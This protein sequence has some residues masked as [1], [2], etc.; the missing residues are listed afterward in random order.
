MKFTETAISGVLLLVPEPA[1]DD[2]GF[3]ARTFDQ[4]EF[5]SRGLASVFVQRSIAFNAKA[6][7]IRGLHYQISPEEEEKIVRCTSGA[8]FDVAVDLRRD[9]PTFGSYS[10]VELTADNRRAFY[11]P[12]GVAHGYQTLSEA[13][14]VMYDISRPYTAEAA[15]GIAYDDPTLAI[16]WPVDVTVLSERD[17]RFPLLAEANLP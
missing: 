9:S 1:Y 7:T 15:R 12:A 10:S 14:E 8:I 13:T 6:G 17:R 11:I 16:S 2:R 3:F 5:A 4:A